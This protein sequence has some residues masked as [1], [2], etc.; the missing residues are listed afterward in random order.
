MSMTL[1]PLPVPR[2]LLFL[3]SILLCGC[4]GWDRALCVMGHCS[5]RD[6]IAERAAAEDL[7]CHPQ[8]LRME[9]IRRYAFEVAGCG[10]IAYYRCWA[11]RRGRGECCT[12]VE[13]DDLR[14]FWLIPRDGREVCLSY[15]GEWSSTA[16]SASASF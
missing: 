10:Q 15:D 12:R 5:H 7:Q 11:V 9:E 3:G 2:I 16:E 1:R 4:A 14:T 6:A 8:N 13:K